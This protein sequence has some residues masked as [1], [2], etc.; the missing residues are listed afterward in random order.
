MSLPQW[1][2]PVLRKVFV[3]M[4]CK[5]QTAHKKEQSKVVGREVNIGEQN[6]KERHRQR[7]QMREREAVV[8]G[9][10]CRDVL[11][12]TGMA[13]RRMCWSYL[14]LSSWRLTLGDMNPASLA[15]PHAGLG[16]ALWGRARKTGIPSH[17]RRKKVGYCPQDC[18]KSQWSS[19]SI[20]KSIHPLS[21]EMQ[22][23][24]W[25]FIHSNES[26]SND[27]ILT[28]TSSSS[29]SSTLTLCPDDRSSQEWSV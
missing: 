9:R 15:S 12:N 18:V 28:N 6:E 16:P 1:P 10:H 7:G 5:C 21:K 20:H 23:Y 25:Y 17:F 14:R 19:S 27:I 24:E 3:C 2:Q 4:Y 26:H 29:C 22:W 11:Q 8:Q 13:S